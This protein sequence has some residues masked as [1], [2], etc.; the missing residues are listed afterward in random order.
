MTSGDLRDRDRQ[1]ERAREHH[2]LWRSFK[3]LLSGGYGG[4]P[5]GLPR[6]NR[7]ASSDSGPSSAHAHPSARMD[8]STSFWDVDGMDYGLVPSFL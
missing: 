7:L 8:F 5:S 4:G 3:S 2:V 1:R 6:A